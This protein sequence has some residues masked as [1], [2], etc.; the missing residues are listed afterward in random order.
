MQ[1]LFSNLRRLALVLG[2]VMPWA[3]PPPPVIAQSPH[4]S[5]FH[6]PEQAEDDFYTPPDLGVLTPERLGELLRAEHIRSFTA[7]EVAAAANLSSSA[8]GAEA[9]RVLYLSQGPVDTPQAV[10]GLIVVPTGSAPD[11]GFP[12]L[13]HG[14]A[15][16]GAADTCA[17]SRYTAS[18]RG[19]LPWVAHGYLVAAPDYA[20]LGPPGLHP[21]GVGEVAGFNML[22]AARAVLRFCDGACTVPGAVANRIFLEGYS[23]GGHAALFAHELWDTYAPELHL[24]GTVVFAPGSELRFLAQQMA[25]KPWSLTL[26]PL[27]LAMYGYG[28]YYGAPD[29]LHAWL[30]ESYATELPHRAETQCIV[31]IADWLG[32]RSDAVLQ[33]SLLT[34]LREENWEAL[35]PWT[36]YIDRNTPGNYTSNAPVFVAHGEMDTLIPP[37]ASQ[38]LAQRLC[39]RGT[40]VKLSRYASSSHFNIVTQALFDAMDW[41]DN[42]LA[43]EPV[44]NS[45]ADFNKIYLPIIIH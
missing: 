18:L 44:T 30:T 12:V 21:Y 43:N 42:R 19:L 38:R 36:E 15:T 37:E 39:R 29:H 11:G 25:E 2:L 40:P 28:K 34:A 23:Q 16:T 24:L 8:Y 5:G 32:V 13:V 14:H 7:E 9:Y 3:Q 35:Q 20:G 33:P 27:L 41:M 10:S 6:A 31:G 22:D 4:R 26:G 1:R 45:C 17:P